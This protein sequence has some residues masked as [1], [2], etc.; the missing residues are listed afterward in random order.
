MGSSLHFHANY[1]TDY[2][3]ILPNLEQEPAPCRVHTAFVVFFNG[4]VQVTRF[5]GN[6][7]GKISGFG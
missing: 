7:T 2:D 3:V 6:K 4:Q 1:T 5:S